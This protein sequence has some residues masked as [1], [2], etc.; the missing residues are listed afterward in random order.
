MADIDPYAVLGVRRTATREEIAR[1]Y[2]ALAKRHHPDAGAPPSAEMG[3]INDAWRTLSDPARRASWDLRHGVTPVT[4]ADW[5]AAP[6]RPYPQPAGSPRPDQPSREA[7]APPSA[8]GSGWAVAA[9]VAGIAIAI[10]VVLAGVA[11]VTRPGDDR[12]ALDTPALSLRHDRGWVRSVG[13]GD[14]PPEHRVVAH[15]ATWNAD[16]ARLCTTYGE[17]CGIQASAIPPGEA[18]ILVTSHEGGAPPVADPADADIG[19]AASAY[20]LTAV[21]PGLALAWWQLSPPGFP[22]RWIEVRALVRETAPP[23]SG[24]E[25]LEEIEEMLATVEFAGS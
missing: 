18:L 16:P 20:D 11:I 10:G 9:A 2:R 24:S 17:E 22:D 12:I 13:D 1:A 4:S 5:T 21:E 15:L 7:A 23:Q 3:R 19:G 25:V 14:D 6:P 8:P